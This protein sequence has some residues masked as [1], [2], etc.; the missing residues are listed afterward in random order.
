MN[1]G[2]ENKELERVAVKNNIKIEYGCTL[3]MLKINI[4]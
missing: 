3:V 1:P 2:T 4:F